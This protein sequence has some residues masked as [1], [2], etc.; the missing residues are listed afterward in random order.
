MIPRI[1]DNRPTL[2][3]YLFNL[4]EWPKES[5]HLSQLEL[6]H[7]D[8]A[9]KLRQAMRRV[10][11]M[12]LTKVSVQE[13]LGNVP[14]R[15]SHTHHVTGRLQVQ[16]GTDEVTEVPLPEVKVRIHRAQ[17]QAQNLF[18]WSLELNK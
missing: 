8:V 7:S 14:L 3:S 9:V 6:V 4:A 15:K 2:S 10:Q 12:Q 1:P 16:F 18:V 11:I 17:H 13:A 5:G